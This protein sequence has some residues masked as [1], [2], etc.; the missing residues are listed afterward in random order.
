[1]EKKTIVGEIYYVGSFA[2]KTFGGSPTIVEAPPIF[3]NMQAAIKMGIG[4]RAEK[5]FKTWINQINF[6]H[7]AVTII[8]VSLTLWMHY[9]HILSH[10]WMTTGVISKIVVTLS[11]TAET[12]AVIT[13]RVVSKGQIYW[14][15]K[16]L[17][18]SYKSL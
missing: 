8:N 13:Q 5:Q 16:A 17:E 6:H 4:S 10:N 11:K 3:E 15:K 7:T 1:M 2:I 14:Y 18:S 9:L 12:T